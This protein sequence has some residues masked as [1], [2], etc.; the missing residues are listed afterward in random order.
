[1]A[2]SVQSF[3]N[4]G[5]SGTLSRKRD[6]RMP[7]LDRIT[8]YPVKSLDGVDVEECRVLPSGALENDRR[9]RLVDM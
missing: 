3:G 9:W 5:W 4:W 8:I 6:P 1:M 7:T 2:R